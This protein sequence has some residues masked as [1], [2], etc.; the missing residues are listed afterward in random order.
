M[1]S[2]RPRWSLQAPSTT[3]VAAF[4]SRASLQHPT[5]TACHAVTSAG[6]QHNRCCSLQRQ[7]RLQHPTSTACH[8]VTSAGP[9]H[10]TKCTLQCSKTNLALN[11]CAHIGMVAQRK[12]CTVQR[13]GDLSAHHMVMPAPASSAASA[14]QLHTAAP[15]AAVMARS[16]ASAH[17]TS[18][19]H[20]MRS[21]LASGSSADWHS[22]LLGVLPVVRLYCSSQS[23]SS[24][25]RSY[26]M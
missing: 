20:S 16:V 5:S 3:G 4:S 6:P 2:S 19:F 23:S 25:S 12:Q 24:Q 10:N 22:R 26:S 1:C 9:Q 13:Q 18:S 11:Y 14:I 7:G 17:A 8:A 15:P 21:N